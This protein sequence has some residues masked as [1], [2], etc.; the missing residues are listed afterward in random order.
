MKQYFDYPDKYYIYSEPDEY[1][2]GEYGLFIVDRKDEKI[3]RSFFSTQ[4]ISFIAKT[5]GKYTLSVTATKSNM[6]TDT[7][8]HEIYVQPGVGIT[9]TTG[10]S[11]YNLLSSKKRR[12]IF[13]SNKGG[14]SVWC[15][16][17]DTLNFKSR[18]PLNSERVNGQRSAFDAEEKYLYLETAGGTGYSIR[19]I[20]VV[21]VEH[22]KLTALHK[23]E[24][25]HVFSD[26]EDGAVYYR[27]GNDIFTLTGN[28]MQRIQTIPFDNLFIYFSALD[29]IYK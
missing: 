21:S 11:P 13:I 26:L 1:R 28:D 8:Q 15:Y 16:D 2:L 14:Y 5:P 25:G 29:K 23:V 27:S 4:D 22:E 10:L 18:I 19:Y 6:E 12:K 20:A 9:N 7:I 3:F 17:Y 24:P